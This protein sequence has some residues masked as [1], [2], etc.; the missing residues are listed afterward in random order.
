MPS[1]SI[2]ACAQ[3]PVVFLSLEEGDRLTRQKF[4]MADFPSSALANITIYFDWRRGEDGVLDLLR[5]LDARPS[6]RYIAIDSLTKVR[7]VPDARQR[8]FEADYQAVSA[9]HEVVKKRPGLCI[10]VVHH[11]RKAKSDDPVEDISGTFGVSAAC[12]VYSIMRPHEG[13]RAILHVGGRLWDRE[14][15][16]FELRRERQRWQLVGAALGLSHAQAQALADLKRAGSL[17][18]SQASVHWNVSKQ[19]AYERLKSL[20]AKGVAVSNSGTYHPT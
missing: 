2:E 4:E 13:G 16:E 18:P 20:V 9:L 12:D 6:V 10:D 7:A 1:S 17:T 15:S 8:A 11:T 14:Q 3:S 5:L 19:S